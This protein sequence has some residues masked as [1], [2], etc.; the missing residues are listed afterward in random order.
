[1]VAMGCGL[2]CMSRD[3]LGLHIGLGDPRAG[4]IGN[5]LLALVR[6]LRIDSILY[7]AE[8]RTGTVDNPHIG[9][10]P[11][12]FWTHNDRPPRVSQLGLHD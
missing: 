4:S 11:Y 5:N 2:S 9:W 3:T 12:A 1:M 7:Y 6:I 8:R 10:S